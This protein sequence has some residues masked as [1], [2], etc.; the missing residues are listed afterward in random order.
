MVAIGDFV[1]ELVDATTKVP[2]QEHQHQGETYV[3]VEPGTEY[4]IAIRKPQATQFT[5]ALYVEPYVDGNHMKYYIPYSA[6]YVSHTASYKGFWTYESENEVSTNQALKFVI[7][8]IRGSGSTSNGLGKVELQI[9]KAI[10]PRTI[11]RQ[12]H[13]KSVKLSA[14]AAGGGVPGKKTVR[15]EYGDSKYTS[16]LAAQTTH[17][18]K[19]QWLSTI[20]LNYCATPGL[21]QMGVIPPHNPDTEDEGDDQK[22][23]PSPRRNKKKPKIKTESKVSVTIDLTEAD[24]E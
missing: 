23:K 13:S 4:F 3:E 20:T 16:N 19:G 5:F 22:P 15:T 17:Y 12:S 18:D 21:I 9:Y 1:V 14:E 10:N 6:G 11:Y 8:K 7:P 24:S 2:F